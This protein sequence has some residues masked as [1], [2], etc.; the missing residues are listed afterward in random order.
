MTNTTPKDAKPIRK[1]SDAATQPQGR[2]KAKP[3]VDSLVEAIMQQS[4]K[5]TMNGKPN[6]PEQA[7]SNEA[8]VKALSN[9]SKNL[10]N[11]VIVVCAGLWLYFF[12]MLHESNYFHDKVGKQ[13]LTTQVAFKEQLMLQ[14][15]KDA[16]DTKKFTQLLRV[17]NLANKIVALDLESEVLNYIRPQGRRVIPRG[18]DEDARTVYQIINSDGHVG[19][20]DEAI[21]LQAENQRNVQKELLQNTLLEI[22]REAES[23]EETS[24]KDPAIKDDW[25]ALFV[26][27]S[28]ISPMD[29]NFPSATTKE[30]VS[31]AK[32]ISQKI[33]VAVSNLNLE[34]L[35][36]DIKKQAQ[37]IDFSGANADTLT[38]ITN[39]Q[40]ILRGISTNRPSSFEQALNKA[41][42]LGI[43]NID[44]NAIYLKATRIIGDPNAAT[45]QGDLK[46]AAIIAK[47]LGR[48]N[49]INTLNMQKIE[50]SNVIKHVETIARLGA[51]LE[52]DTEDTVGAQMDIDPDG[53]LVTFS[54]F[55][56]KGIKGVIDVRGVALEGVSYKDRNFTLLSDLIDAFEGS[57]YFKDVDGFSF[58]KKKDQDGL[59]SAPLN[60][61]LGLQALGE[62]DSRDIQL[63]I[64]MN[65]AAEPT[66]NVGVDE[67]YNLNFFSTSEEIAAPSLESA[68]KDSDQHLPADEASPGVY[69]HLV[70]TFYSLSI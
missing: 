6:S 38:I 13:N 32:S 8:E 47:N 66:E 12:A 61:K 39:L 27:L 4:K 17:E 45:N 25:A 10:L 54:G 30:F 37:A 65:T 15:K 33:L 53:K 67:I 59:I 16:A 5:D 69:G 20:I 43:E 34:N 28:A 63:G 55:S 3:S 44:N 11:V 56:G 46:A 2:E 50:W 58:S 49:T 26:E 68:T 29:D 42:E 64:V 36:V 31:S 21:I 9:F 60:F 22:L 35:V 70:E 52:R 41:V 48:V 19:V 57:K 18:E 1:K 14:L 62:K 51:D 24:I 23:L 7:K 40:T